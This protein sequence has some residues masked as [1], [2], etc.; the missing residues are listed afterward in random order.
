MTTP[1]MT[2]SIGT[3]FRAYLPKERIRDL[4]ETEAGLAFV[5]RQRITDGVWESPGPEPIGLYHVVVHAA[6]CQLTATH[7]GRIRYS[8]HLPA[9]TIQFSRA[10][11]EVRC[12]GHGS[13]RF[14]TVLHARV[15]GW[16]SRLA[17]GQFRRRR[18]A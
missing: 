14:L 9:N 3:R 12:A 13:I 16:A 4:W 17:V 6:D 1:S 15:P 11:E 7:N 18:A 8:G 5:Q 2:M 10:D